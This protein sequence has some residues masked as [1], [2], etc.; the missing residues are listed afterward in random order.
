[1]K[2]LVLGGTGAIGAHLVQLLSE[3]ET[4]TVVTSRYAR[5]PER[6]IKYIQGD[7]HNMIFMQSILKKQWDAIID[8]MVYDTSSF[9][10]RVDLLLKS[11]KQY[12][13][14]SSA[15]VYA[16]SEQAITETSPRLL[17]V[18]TDKEFLST[19]EYS[20]SKARQEDILKNSS[21]KNWTIIRPYITYN[22]N[23][24]QLGVLEKEDWLY[25]AVHGR[26]IVFSNDI[27]NSQ[28]TLSYGLDVSKGIL[29]TIGNSN[30]LGNSFHITSE[31]SN[32][33]KDILSLYL[34]IL[35]SHLKFRPNILLLDI[36]DFI[37]IT[38]AK[39]QVKFDRIYNRTFD[40]SKISQ[41]ININTFVKTKEGLTFCL[42]EFLKNPKFKAINWKK[43]AL[44][45]RKTGELTPFKEIKGIKRKI[46]YITFRYIPYIHKI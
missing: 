44:K 26:T 30:T 15:R 34:D 13:F 19:D 35:E 8:F 2:V 41:H 23:R 20:L 9:K 39:H 4:E 46:K 37:D 27:S 25:R 40:N 22:K 7:A 29:A 1:M 31:D 18:S 42:G 5:E 36:N 32:S 43:E 45:D 3:N 21:K 16:N 38:K 14:L 17:D 11:T 28:T 6:N 10:K 12:V 33:W 24:F